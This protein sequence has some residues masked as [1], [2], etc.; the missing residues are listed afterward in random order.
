MP[1][2]QLE[3]RHALERDRILYNTVGF[4]L[5][6]LVAALFFRRASLMLVAAGPPLIAILFAL[7]AL[8][9]F[10]FR[11]NM[12][13]NVMTPLIMVISFSD[14][15]QLTFAARDRLMA[16]DDKRDGI[17]QGDTRS[18]DRPASSPTRPRLCPSS[19]CTFS[20]AD[21]IREFGE[22]GL[23]ATVIALVTV[24]SLVPVLG[25]LLIRDEA[26]FVATLNTA[27]PG[28]AGAAALLRLDRRRMV[29]PAAR[30]TASLGLAVVAWL[31]LRLFRICSRATGSPTR[32]PTREQAT[33]ASNR[34]D[35]ELH[36]RQSD[37]RADHVSQWRRASTRRRRSPRSPTCTRRSRA[38]PGVGNVW[39][40]ETLRRWLA[41][42]MGITDVD[43]LKQY[44]DVLPR[45]LV[46]RFIRRPQ[47][48]RDRFGRRA[49]QEPA[50][51]CCRSSTG[52]KRVSTRCARAI[53]AIRFR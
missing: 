16:G 49:R 47:H 15:M 25:V 32:C 27:D 4:A 33:Q 19:A 36:R 3:I 42:K 11:L 35:A 31:G 44:V 52:S 1:V 6:C 21:L 34:L 30:S 24:L 20:R 8:G 12:F 26:R 2:M 48:A 53:P 29:T 45:Y 23:L 17:S 28:V 22:A 41:D 51:G 18:S 46:R 10:G 43:A 5:G 13:L 50:G 40:L 37:R 7:G 14:S 9:W 38:S 39:S